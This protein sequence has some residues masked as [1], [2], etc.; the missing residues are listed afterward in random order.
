MSSQVAAPAETGTTVVAVV[1]RASTPSA[2]K[3]SSALNN[4]RGSGRLTPRSNTS[5]GGGGAIAAPHRGATGDGA[6]VAGKSSSS[7]NVPH[8]GRCAQN[9]ARTEAVAAQLSAVRG[10][11]A[12]APAV[13][14]GN[15]SASLN[16]RKGGRCHAN[17]TSNANVLAGSILKG[18]APAPGDA[19]FVHFH[20]KRR[21]QPNSTA[22]VVVPIS[23]PTSMSPLAKAR[24]RAS[25]VD[26]AAARTSS[27]S[28]LTAITTTIAPR[29]APPPKPEPLQPFLIIGGSSRD[30]WGAEARH[31]K[32]VMSP[33]RKEQTAKRL[34]EQKSE[35]GALVKASG[36][37]GEAA[38]SG[39]SA[40]AN[41]NDGAAGART[42]SSPVRG[43][44]G[45]R[46][47]PAEPLAQQE[48]LDANSG[49]GGGS[50]AGPVRFTQPP[51]WDMNSKTPRNASLAL[52]TKGF[53]APKVAL[54]SDILS[55]L[56]KSVRMKNESVIA[57]SFPGN[58]SASR[59]AAATNNNNKRASSAPAVGTI[60]TSSRQ[61]HMVNHDAHRAKGFDQCIGRKRTHQQAPH[62]YQVYA[63][64][65]ANDKTRVFRIHP[66]VEHKG[67]NV[68]QAAESKNQ[69]NPALVF[70]GNFDGKAAARNS[71]F[72]L[73]HAVSCAGKAR[74]G[75]G[76]PAK[77]S[78][79]GGGGVTAQQLVMQQMERANSAPR[80]STFRRSETART[81]SSLIESPFD[82]T[83]NPGKYDPTF[84]S[85][86][87]CR[88]QKE[89]VRPMLKPKVSAPF[90]SNR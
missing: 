87:T 90:K 52:P 32:Y 80:T 37:G 9:T 82:R 68:G 29:T 18:D 64:T 73:G 7:L 60:M 35:M 3:S 19:S 54:S 41:K 33:Q 58:N 61:P 13:T 66:L 89:Y 50:G 65:L 14:C 88:T 86:T 49:T 81:T 2:G 67:K 6:P 55:P 23:F 10:A 21:L 74:A 71:D 77:K 56:R 85:R 5:G 78:G 63:P 40:A 83:C 45:K 27:S 15:S 31:K 76:V 12:A 42:A 46:I 28:A 69:Q 62:E 38:P 57:E 36:G 48:Q 75:M 11:T 22:N 20:I 16:T 26:D 53:Q 70:G 1:A 8:S 84:E 72:P 24:G 59:G 79:G 25:S 17:H 30:E 43:H 47:R 44:T 51:F 4:N 34:I 39:T